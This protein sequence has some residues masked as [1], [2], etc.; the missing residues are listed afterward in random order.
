MRWLSYGILIVF[1]NLFQNDGARAEAIALKFEDLPKL[2]QERNQTI[3]GTQLA[4]QAYEKRTGY[5]VRSYLPTLQFDGG[6][7]HFQTGSYPSRTEPYA[8]LETRLNLFRGGKD[9]LE[10]DVRQSQVKLTQ[11]QAQKTLIEELTDARKTFWI[12]IFQRE[13]IQILKDAFKENDKN[14]VAA[15][16]RIQ[17]GLTSDTDQLDFEI[18]RDVLNEEIASLEHE[19]ELTQ[20]KLRSFFSWSDEKL[21]QTSNQIPHDHDEALLRTEI[22]AESHPEVSWIKAN[23]RVALSQ[24][25][26]A[27]R[28]WTPSVEVYAGYYLFTL[29]DRDYLDFERR[30]DRVAGVR[31]SIPLFDGLQSKAIASS[32]AMQGDALEMQAKQ[33]EKIIQA[34]FQIAKEEI[35]HHHELTHVAESRI[36]MGG[37][38]LAKTLSEYDRGVKNSPDVMGALQRQIAFRRRYAEIKRDYQLFKADLLG[39]LNR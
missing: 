21:I 1:L 5:L 2:L 27:K 12:L 39:L 20:I 37:R 24:G 3:Q 31:L 34:K 18:N 14:L 4:V 10:E 8:F 13:M 19:V 6:G 25:S 35:K 28:W 9:I 29:R 15:K 11:S 32:L 17:R 33:K 16:R 7:E 23:S 22:P 36:V 26:Q 38:Y 30:D